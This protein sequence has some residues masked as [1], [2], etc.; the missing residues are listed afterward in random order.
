MQCLLAFGLEGSGIDLHNMQQEE[1]LAIVL[2]RELSELHLCVSL[3]QC[4]SPL[5]AM[6]GVSAAAEVSAIAQAMALH[7]LPWVGVMT[8]ADPELI[9]FGCAAGASSMVASAELTSSILAQEMRRIAESDRRTVTVMSTETIG[10]RV[11][12]V[13]DTVTMRPAT[14]GIL[15]RGVLALQRSDIDGNLVLFGI[16]GPGDAVMGD[17]E[18]LLAEESYIGLAAG[19]VMLMTKDAAIRESVFHIA[20]SSRLASMQAWAR[21]Q[22]GSSA[23]SRILQTFRVLAKLAGRPHANGVLLDARITHA[24]LAAAVGVN[25]T[26]VTRLLGVLRQRGDLMKVRTRDN[27]SG[28]WLLHAQGLDLP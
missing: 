9:A 3:R 17:S 19:S 1:P 23:E 16:A 14:V 7:R 2:L 4:C 20:Q 8:R 21:A 11:F 6:V 13:G 26:T 18:G 22:A 27:A 28:G 24:Q 10:E 5:L 25:R 12:R 15:R